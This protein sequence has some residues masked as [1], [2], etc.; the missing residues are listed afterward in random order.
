VRWV[1]GRSRR[2]GVGER[3]WSSAGATAVDSRFLRVQSG[4]GRVG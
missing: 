2:D 3:L 4:R 1:A